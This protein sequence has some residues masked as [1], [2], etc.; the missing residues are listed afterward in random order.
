[1]IDVNATHE[2]ICN[3]IL[4]VSGDRMIKRREGVKAIS[5]SIQRAASMIPEVYIVPHQLSV[6]LN[7]D[8]RSV[9]NGLVFLLLVR[10]GE[11]T[12]TICF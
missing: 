6:V 9:D 8:V 4:R 7:T 11:E 12:I 3:G 1:V 5:K 10:W 2:S